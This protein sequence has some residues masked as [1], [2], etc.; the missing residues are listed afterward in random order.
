VGLV[1]TDWSGAAAWN[2]FPSENGRYPI[3][4]KPILSP[5]DGEVVFVENTI[6]DNLPFGQPRPYNL[7][8]RIVIGNGNV[9]VLL[10]HHRCGTIGLG[11]GD[12]V[13]AGDPVAQAGNSGWTERP[14]L[15]MQ[16]TGVTEPE[17]WKNNGVLFILNGSNPV[18]NTR[19]FVRP[20]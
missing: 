7:G 19:F 1:E 2:L 17:L 3:S 16:A 8:N 12:R 11:V 14:H 20:A 13:K 18:K 15:H 6:P 4:G 9:Q 10:G 5:L